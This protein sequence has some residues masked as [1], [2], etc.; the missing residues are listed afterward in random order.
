MFLPALFCSSKL[1]EKLKRKSPHAPICPQ[2]LDENLKIYLVWPKPTKISHIIKQVKTLLK[3]ILKQE[4]P[5]VLD[6]SHEPWHMKR[7]WLNSYDL[8]IF[9]L[10]T[11]VAISEHFKLSSV[12][13]KFTWFCRRHHEEYVWNYFQLGSVV[14]Y[15]SFNNIFYLELWRPLFSVEP[16]YMYLWNFGNGHYNMR[17]ISVKWYWI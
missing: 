5:R 11:L 1:S 8:K 15:M 6:H 4:G 10:L 9:L 13:S 17:N 7:W 16:Y 3:K 2:N 14:Q 12:N